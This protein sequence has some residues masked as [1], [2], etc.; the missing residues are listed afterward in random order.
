MKLR[1]DRH[2]EFLWAQFRKANDI[3]G[4]RKC[5]YGVYYDEKG[6]LTLAAV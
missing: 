6:P 3:D 1:I 2:L 4:T 5:F